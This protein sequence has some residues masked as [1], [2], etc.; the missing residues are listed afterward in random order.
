MPVRIAARSE[1]IRPSRY[2][3]WEPSIIPYR[4]ANT[5]LM[6]DNRTIRFV[7]ND[8]DVR[9]RAYNDKHKKSREWFKARG[10][11]RRLLARLSSVGSIPRFSVESN[12]AMPPI[13]W[14]I[15]DRVRSG[16]SSLRGCNTMRTRGR[17]TIAE[18]S[19]PVGYSWDK[20]HA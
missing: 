16:T 6:A 8:K 19:A 3:E 17:K 4:W 15:I 2:L 11:T 5:S 18:T 9:S 12:K 14:I 7:R 13:R 1:R 20:F 10:G